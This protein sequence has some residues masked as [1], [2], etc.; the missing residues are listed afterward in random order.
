[1]RIT[2]GVLITILI[3]GVALASD[4]GRR[5]SYVFRDGDV[6]W[7]LGEG[8]SASALKEIQA[9]FGREF[10]W[11]RRSGQVFVSHDDHVLDQA[12]LAVQRNLPRAEQERR[13]ATIADAGV[14]RR[15]YVL[16][17]DDTRTTISA[18]T[19]IESIKGIRRRYPG[20]F[21]WVR[22]DGKSWLIQ[23]PDWIDRASAFFAEQFSLAPQQTAVS[24]EEEELD[25]EEDR[26]EDR[27]DDASRT[28]LE[29]VR[30]RQAEVS[31]REA[32]LDEREEELER[33]AESKLWVLVD[34]AIR[35]GVARPA[36]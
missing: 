22:V 19:T 24:R 3:A 30:R 18:G 29:E 9:R 32:E 23:D 15:S 17:F 6:T 33:E 10:L 27:R 4:T 2:I 34:N 31:R 12:R 14:N 13:L 7:M 11:A 25:K 26:L 21:L 1:M 5:D 35:Q 28:R 36:R 8:M 20:R 16:A